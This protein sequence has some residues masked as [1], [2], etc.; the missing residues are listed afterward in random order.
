MQQDSTQG[1]R[2]T[3]PIITKRNNGQLYLTPDILIIVITT[4]IPIIGIVLWFYLLYTDRRLSNLALDNGLLF[5]L[6][7]FGC[8]F[9]LTTDFSLSMFSAT[10]LN[11]IFYVECLTSKLEY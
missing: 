5:F 4:F 3:S 2:V 1:S 9:Y 10:G 8:Y 11:L 6:I 7:R